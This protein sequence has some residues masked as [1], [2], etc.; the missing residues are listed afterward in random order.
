MHM[1]LAPGEVFEHRHSGDS[2]TTLLD[3]SVDLIVGDTRTA[4]VVDVATPIPAHVSHQLINTGLVPATL[5]CVHEVR[6]PPP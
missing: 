6:D 4:L 3:G 1:V 5:K 2:T